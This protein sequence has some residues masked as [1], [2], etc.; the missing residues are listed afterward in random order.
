LWKR[1]EAEASAFALPANWQEGRAEHRGFAIDAAYSPDIDDAIRLS[2]T[3]DSG[4][5]HVS[6]ADVGTFLH[7]KPAIALHAHRRMRTKYRGEAILEPMLPRPICTDTLSLLD[8]Q[9]R[10]VLTAHI[11]VNAKGV[12]DTQASDPM[13]RE[14]LRARQLDSRQVSDISQHEHS[15]DA[16]A[17][18][19]L[20]HVATALANRRRENGFSERFEWFDEEDLSAANNEGVGRLIVAESMIAVNAIVGQFMYEQKIPA[21]YR[22]AVDWGQFVEASYD[23][24]PKGHA[25]LGIPMYMHFSSPLRR[26]VD[27]ANHC[28]LIAH[29]ENRPYPY[30]EEYLSYVAQRTNYH[31]PT[32]RKGGR[33]S[34]RAMQRQMVSERSVVYLT[35]QI[36]NKSAQDSQL[37]I[38][39]FGATGG[40][41]A[42]AALKAKAAEYIAQNIE[43]ASNILQIAL[44]KRLVRL[45][46]LPLVDPAK[47]ARILEDRRGN[48]YPYRSLQDPLHK[49]LAI[50]HLFGQVANITISPVV[51]E[52]MSHEA[53]MIR[54]GI[55][56]L[57]GLRKQKRLSFTSSISHEEDRVVAYVQVIVGGK[58]HEQSASGG[59][60]KMAL[61]EA[62]AQLIRDLDLVA[63]IPPVQESP[64]HASGQGGADSNRN[65]IVTL[66]GITHA[67]GMEVDYSYS[68]NVL[69]H[70]VARVTGADGQS[71]LVEETGTKKQD[72]R[73]KAAAALLRQLPPGQ[74]RKRVTN[75]RE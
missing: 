27:F 57:A 12:A 35:E 9:P 5:L 72:A 51:P 73:Q 32:F 54:Q 36:D 75:H 43:R 7:D 64:R 26:F 11:L 33:V 55:H 4:I 10:P 24:V 65:P 45:I 16:F 71:Y 53:K 37:A 28:N 63:N 17:L 40:D 50:S 61:R 69:W 62:S 68:R 20:E 46:P 41:Q 14:V 3:P 39:L 42:V 29:M 23:I 18:L 44:D 74:A 31:A 56:Y 58:V 70:C 15:P 47:G 34:M 25:A 2:G 22:N 30:S 67:A 6:I 1:A 21:I 38:A 48:T 66:H 8:N 13:G 60:E 19:G 49:A 59:S 52:H